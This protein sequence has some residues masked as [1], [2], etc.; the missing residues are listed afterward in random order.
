MYAQERREMGRAVAL[1]W[2]GGSKGRREQG[3]KRWG[4]AKA[5]EGRHPLR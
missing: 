2:E 1:L 3:G 5:L 4:A